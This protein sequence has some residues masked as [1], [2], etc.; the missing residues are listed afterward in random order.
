MA[1]MTLGQL[2]VTVALLASLGLV[3]SRFG[4]SAIPAYLLAG[5]LLG[6]NEPTALS[7]IKPSEVTDFVAQLGIVFLLFFLGLEFSG[8]RLFRSGRHVGLGG[9]V[10]LVV[11]GGLGVLLGV[12]AFGAGLGSVALAIAVYV[13]SSAITVKA[14]IDFKRLADDETD[15]VLAILVFEDLVLAFALGFVGGAGGGATDTLLVVAKAVCFI[16]LSLAAS[17][18]LSRPLDTLLDRLP[19]EFFLLAVVAFVVGMAAISNELGLSDAIGALMAGVVLAETSIRE[20]IEERF[21]SFRDLFAAL[22]FFVFGLSIDVGALGRTG[23]LLAAAVVVTVV[24]KTASGYV[25][26]LAGGLNRRQSL[27]AGI[28]LIAHGEFTVIVAQL[29]AGNDAI[30]AST[31]DDIVAFS[32]LYVLATATIGVVLMKESKALGRRL[33][34]VRRLA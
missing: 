23:W 7:V 29:A 11:N 13:S 22:F 24:G 12:I 19:R 6:P 28:A 33:F 3:A 4:L 10:D 18:W 30:G 1:P 5:L 34:P 25:A 2:A 9:S 17:R 14:L 15:L 32:G 31:R 26:G 27:N 20:E 8:S 21:F 16:G